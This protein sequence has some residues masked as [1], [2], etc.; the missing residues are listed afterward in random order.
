MV[1]VAST[2]LVLFIAS[3]AVAAGVAGAFTTES[4]RLSA[5]L[6]DLGV[7]VS[8]EVGTDI[9][10]V[11]DAAGPV[12]DGDAETITLN[13]RNNGASTPPHEAEQIDVILDGTYQSSGG[14]SVAVQGAASWAPNEVV[15]IT[16]DA[17][18]LAWGDHRVK[19]AVDGDS[20]VLEFRNCAGV[21]RDSI[22]FEQNA[23]KELAVIDRSGTITDLGVKTV[24]FSPVMADFDCD[25]EHEVAYIAEGDQTINIVGL[26]GEAQELTSTSIGQTDRRLAVGDLDGDG[27]PAVIYPNGSD[28][29]NLY[30]VEV[31]EA[32]ERIGAGFA[33]RSI[34]GVADFNGDGD[35]DIVYLGTNDK[36]HFLDDET[37]TDTGTKARDELAIGSPM[38]FD[39]DGTVR[40]PIRTQTGQDIKLVD[41]NGNTETINSD[42]SGSVGSLASLDWNEDGTPDVLSSHQGDGRKIYVLELDGTNTAITDGAGNTVPTSTLGVA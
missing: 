34:G 14:L 37:A 28:N 13:V 20:D 9:Q 33:A 3:I 32:P 35:L 23:N 8:D 36:V 6:E 17:P 42:Y 30:R 15:E 19:I 11:T 16:I 21:S 38:D 12:Y 40:V 39:G 24:G 29:D 5:T 26:D 10:I 7:D 41:S 2:H 18:D 31:D 25:G 27:A 1:S 22:A 4:S